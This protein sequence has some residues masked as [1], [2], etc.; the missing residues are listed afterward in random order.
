MAD[1]ATRREAAGNNLYGQVRHKVRPPALGRS[2]TAAGR[3]GQAPADEPDRR[4][5]LGYARQGV[6][7]RAE[8]EL[9]AGMAAPVKSP[10]AVRG[11][12]RLLRGRGSLRA[13]GAWPGGRWRPS[14]PRCDPR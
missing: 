10:S 7:S 13:A 1:S 4:G 6:S 2:G 5:E 9:L 12:W 3:F 14:V 8:A 11:G